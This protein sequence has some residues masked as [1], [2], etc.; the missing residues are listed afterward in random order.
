MYRVLGPVSTT[1]D[2]R[3]RAMDIAIH[4]AVE[5]RGRPARRRARDTRDGVLVAGGGGGNR[6]AGRGRTV[7]VACCARTS[8]C[9]A[10][11]H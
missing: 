7:R 5:A 9:L 8:G 2:T 1:I 6:R 11:T 3:S 10:C 4:A